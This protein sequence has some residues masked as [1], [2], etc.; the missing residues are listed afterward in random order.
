MPGFS[1]KEQN[2]EGKGVLQVEGGR[3]GKEKV[4]GGEK[5]GERETRRATCVAI[6]GTR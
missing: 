5:R 4:P 3:D 2:G 1:G 6:T